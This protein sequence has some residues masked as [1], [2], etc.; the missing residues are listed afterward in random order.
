[1]ALK[2]NEIKLSVVTISYNGKKFLERCIGS[3]LSGKSRGFEMIFVDNGS[4]D[5]S[6]E[7]V[8]EKFGKDRRLRMVRLE[9]NVGPAEARN[10]GVTKSRGEYILILDNDTKIKIGWY[11]KTLKFIK[12]NRGFGMAQPKLLTMGTNRFN[13]AGD[14]ISRFG[15]LAERSRLTEDKGQ[16]DKVEE[17]F[18]LNIASAL[19][20]KDVFLKL[21]GFDEDYFFYWEEPDLCWRYWLMGY[22]V[23]F[24][25]EIVVWHAF[26]TEEK[27]VDYYRKRNRL[28]QASYLGCRNMM[29]TLIKNLETVNLFFILPVNIFCWL[30]LGAMFFFELEFKR[31]GAIPRA[32]G[33]NVINLKRTLEKRKKIQKER[34]VKDREIFSL[35]GISRNLPWY[36]GKG[37]SYVLGRPF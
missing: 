33:W 36:L 9:K 24:A 20:E 17:I 34:V 26:G 23:L 22:K 35:V 2:K 18:S 37:V 1:M 14:Y 16:F 21:G 3:V 25:P 10:L 27:N 28:Y 15:F 6:L 4:S 32:I 8:K 30:I 29:A 5:G 12:E 31:A 7:L 13:Y 19:F 11:P